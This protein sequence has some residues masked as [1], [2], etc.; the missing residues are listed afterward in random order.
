[1]FRV[2]VIYWSNHIAMLFVLVSHYIP[3]SEFME[4]CIQ[5]T[6]S[7]LLVL[8]IAMSDEFLH[9]ISFCTTV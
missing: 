9:F 5:C 8:D 1:M 4:I 6:L 2:W 3:D 7:L